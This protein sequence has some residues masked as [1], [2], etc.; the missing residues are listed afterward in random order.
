MG[1]EAEDVYPSDVA[2]CDGATWAEQTPATRSAIA[3]IVRIG[4]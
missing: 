2:G 1:I 4:G 3:T